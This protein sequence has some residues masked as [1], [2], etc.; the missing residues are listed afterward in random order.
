MPKLQ[1]SNSDA[2]EGT[3]GELEDGGDGDIGG[4]A[5]AEEGFEVL[6]KQKEYI[7]EEFY[8]QNDTQSNSS[9]SI[10]CGMKRS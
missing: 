9:E 10:F 4:V 3:E 8:D 1:T 2:V 7:K 5:G 6:Q